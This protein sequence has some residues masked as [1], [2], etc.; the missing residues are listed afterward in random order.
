MASQELTAALQRASSVLQRRPQA[1][2]H[3]DASASARWLGGLRVVS[4]HANGTQVATDMPA[5]LGGSGDQVSPG[6][7]FRAGFA[8]CTATCIVMTAAIEGIAL[9]AL[10]VHAHS[11]SD[12]RGP[13]GLSEVDGS[14][15][16]AGPHDMQLQVRIA[17][18][19]VPAARLR[20]LV[21]DSY[22]R[23][24]IAR[25]VLDAIPVAVHID[26]GVG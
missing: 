14:P 10:E 6:W 16:Y 13:L 12:T 24:P 19:G 9:N 17:A 11:R 2:I 8:S 5:E 3:A 1:G 18:N 4:G 7:L 21:E 22:Q 15:V 23:S 25:V 26:L 20:Q